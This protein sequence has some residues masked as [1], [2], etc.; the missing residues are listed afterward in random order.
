[1][2]NKKSK[3][4]LGAFFILAVFFFGGLVWWKKNISPVSES[5][6]EISFIITKGLSAMQVANRLY[7]KGLIKSPLAFKIYVQVSDKSKNIN[8]GEFL[9]RRNMTLP[10]LVEVLGEGPLELWVTIP[11]GLR[12]EEIATKFIKELEITDNQKDQFTK[13]FLKASKDKEGYL[14]P[15]TYLFPRDISA[16][17]AVDKMLSTFELKIDEMILSTIEESKYSLNDYVIMASI[18]ERETKTDEERPIVA[19]ILWKRLES[20][21]WLLQADATMQ[22]E[23]GTRNCAGKVFDC[24]DWWPIL[25]REDLEIQSSYN[26]YQVDLLPPTPIAN[27]GLSSL[28]ASI[29][30]EASDYWFYIHDTEGNIHYARNISEHNEN[31]RVYLGK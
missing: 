23:L 30:P 4:L 13:D 17:Q 11:E 7:E 18:I 25:K 27:P 9:L 21:G 24:E 6:E 2:R 10:E 31:V 22:Y 19:G 14:F 28:K 3:I 8:A 5:D 1:M 15:D 26:T 16:K 12:R 20:E 29:F